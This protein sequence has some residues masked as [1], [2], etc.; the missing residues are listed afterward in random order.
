M[1]QMAEPRWEQMAD[2]RLEIE[3]AMADLKRVVILD[4][5]TLVRLDG[6]LGQHQASNYLWG[7]IERYR[8]PLSVEYRQ[9]NGLLAC[10][11]MSPSGWSEAQT[12]AWQHAHDGPWKGNDVLGIGDD[13]VRLVHQEMQLRDDVD[14]RKPA[15]LRPSH[16][17]P[18]CFS[19]IIDLA[20]G[21]GL[22]RYADDL[23]Y[24]EDER[25]MWLAQWLRAPVFYADAVSRD[26]ADSAGFADGSWM[27]AQPTLRLPA[28]RV[29]LEVANPDAAIVSADAPTAWGLLLVEASLYQF[30]GRVEWQAVL[31]R[32]QGIHRLCTALLPSASSAAQRRLRERLVLVEGILERQTHEG[33]EARYVLSS[34]L[35]YRQ[36]QE[37]VYGPTLQGM[38]LLD[39]AYRPLTPLV[40]D[41]AFS[42]VLAARPAL[43]ARMEDD[44]LMWLR[45]AL[46]PLMGL[47]LLSR[48]EL[49]AHVRLTSEVDSRIE[50][51]QL[52]LPTPTGRKAVLDLMSSAVD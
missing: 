24:T 17:T 48:S 36:Q 45:M 20:L 41:L 21:H 9:A 12:L 4:E 27:S 23:T 22:S 35:F 34:G 11:S 5:S 30:G 47:H 28:N 16:A 37:R 2:P 1:Q 29:W 6:I 31:D 25:H 18:R 13:A 14:Q 46:L 49:A 40:A 52:L 33:T 38:I 3:A 8:K 43:Q 39:A 42:W 7:L 32:L 51:P 26:V 10:L 19:A 44:A 15:H 50:E